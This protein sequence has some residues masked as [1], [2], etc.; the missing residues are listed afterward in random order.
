M[1]AS[2]LQSEKAP[3]VLVPGIGVVPRSKVGLPVPALMI[4]LDTVTKVFAPSALPAVLGM[5][6]QLEPLPRSWMITVSERPPDTSRGST[7]WRSLILV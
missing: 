3:V 6:A 1:A 7:S 5:T 4:A 2:V